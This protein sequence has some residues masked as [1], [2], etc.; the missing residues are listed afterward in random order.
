MATIRLMSD[1]FR[2]VLLVV[3]LVYFVVAVR[4]IHRKKLSLNYSLLWLFMLLVLLIMIL[5]PQLVYGL[6]A[7]VGIDLPINMLFTGFAFIS[8]VL[9]FYLTCIVSRENEKS[10]TMAQQIALLEKRIRELEE[11]VK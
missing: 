8:L 11:K 5:F 9:L 4:L 10:R 6:T 2:L 7:L 1:R 3:V